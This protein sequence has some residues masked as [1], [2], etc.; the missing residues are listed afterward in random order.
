MKILFNITVDDSKEIKRLTEFYTNLGYKVKM[1][2]V[3]YGS[4]QINIGIEEVS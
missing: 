1:G 2:S 3:Y 4:W